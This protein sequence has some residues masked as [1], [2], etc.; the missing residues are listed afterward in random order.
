MARL[1]ILAL[2]LTMLGLTSRNSE[3][4]EQGQPSSLLW[5]QFRKDQLISALQFSSHT[6]LEEDRTLLLP[7]SHRC[8]PAPSTPRSGQDHPSSEPEMMWQCLSNRV[9]YCNKVVWL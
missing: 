6:L 4:A 1:F 9:D 2:W 7:A 3:Q 8:E 5:S